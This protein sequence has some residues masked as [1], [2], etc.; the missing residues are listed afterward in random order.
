MRSWKPESS[1]VLNIDWIWL[2]LMGGRIGFSHASWNY[3][4]ITK[5]MAIA[6]V[7]VLSP[8]WVLLVKLGLGA[9]TQ[10]SANLE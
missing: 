10:H 6:T 4:L 2:A 9:H 8:G 7:P 5:S 3:S 1:W